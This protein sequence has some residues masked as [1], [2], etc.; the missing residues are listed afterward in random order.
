MITPLIRADFLRLI[1]HL[2]IQQAMIFSKTAMIVENAAKVIN[3]KKNVPQIL[4][5][6]IWIKT[7]GSVIK[8]S[9]GPAPGLIP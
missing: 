3:R 8:I 9:S 6:G 5:P 4:P 2:S 1:F 7:F